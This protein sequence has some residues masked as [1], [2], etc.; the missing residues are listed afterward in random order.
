M[1]P[2][3]LY[4]SGSALAL[5][6]AQPP[7]G[8]ANGEYGVARLPV[9]M[10]ADALAKPSALSSVLAEQ[11]KSLRAATDLSADCHL[12]LAPE[13][14]NLSLI[15][16]PEVDDDQVVDAVRWTIQDQVDY[17]VDDALLDVFDL[18][19]SASRERP[20][21][22]VVSAQRELLRGLVQRVTDQD[23]RVNCIDVSELA[24]RNLVW[25]CFPGADQSVALL[26]LTANS[27]L[28]SVSRGEE[29]YLSRR[30]S[31]VPTDF[32][33]DNWTEFRERMLLQV[34]RSIDYY[35][36]AMGQPHCNV[37][38][39]ACTH[40]WSNRVCD[41]LTEMLAIPV[42]PISPLLQDE[43]DLSL[44]NPQAEQIDWANL[45]EE[46]TNA[47]AAGLPALGGLFRPALAAAA[48]EAA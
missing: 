32:A 2:A 33:E 35:E 42:R 26:R 48:S 29:L 22:F 4:V 16:R 30:I 34:Q 37:L 27:G 36:S 18:P 45:S 20:M 21:V 43:I 9:C 28:I 24:L 46:Q 11:I 10:R 25:R 3:A 6:Q 19:N 40:G 14:Y 23:L 38:M 1:A 31:G 17:P 41:Y 44:F 15:E 13:M 47:V 5:A 8:Q 39:V 12:I 7:R